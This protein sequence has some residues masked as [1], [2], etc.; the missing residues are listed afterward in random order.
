MG[1]SRQHP[2]RQVHRDGLPTLIIGAGEAG[3]AVV[4][5]I[6]AS[7]GYGLRPIGF[8]DDDPHL[9]RAAGLP[10][11]GRADEVARIAQLSGAKAALVAMPSIAQG[12]VA[13]LIE[14]AASA[15]LMVRYLPSF[16]SAVERDMR[17]SDLRGLRV[18]HLLG[19]DEVHI[20]SDRACNLIHGRRVLVT[21]AGGS[22]GSELCRQISRFEPA[23]LYLLDYDESNLHTLQLELTGSG[24][25]DS[26]DIIVANIRDGRRVDQVFSETKPELVFH[27]AAHKHLPLLERHPCEGVKTNVL[28][29]KHLVEAAMKYGTERFVLISTDKAADPSSV[30][31][32][33]KRL[34]ELVV[35]KAAGGPTC[36]ASVRF[37]NVLGS[38]GSLLAVLAKQVSH[39]QAVTVTHPDVTRFF[40]T[41]EE[42]VSLVLEAATMS[43]YAET[44]VLDMGDPVSIVDLV[45]RYAEEL[46]LSNV[47]IRFTGLRPGE[48][49]NE[50][51]FS[52]TEIR[53]PTSHPKVWAT[54]GASA[55]ED[56]NEMLEEL[57]T[58]AFMNDPGRTKRLLRDMLPEYQPTTYTQT[59]ASV[60]APYPDG[61]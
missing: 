27:A 50:K 13:E 55:P 4:R 47:T 60:G 37:G 21:G 12:R 14:E 28:G 24:L 48:K 34:A 39:G 22:I 33:T 56:L 51:V 1:L 5:A 32:A 23:A 57:F 3:R 30:L 53:L 7:E 16:L 29:T 52:D 31:G 44:F 49:L 25:L 8:L 17:L 2:H 35:Q 36:M 6:R 20:A 42:A 40:M 10:V 59:P 61:F 58:S 41:V 38:R 54:R 26:D 46:H 45:Y 11:L 18:D 9:R 43:E 15:G 19:R